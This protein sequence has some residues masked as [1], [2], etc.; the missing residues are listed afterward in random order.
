MNNRKVIN[1]SNWNNMNQNVKNNLNKAGINDYDDHTIHKLNT[2]S[3]ENHNQIQALNIKP[4]QSEL[5]N[6]IE[7]TD[8]IENNLNNDG[9]NKKEILRGFKLNN[10][11]LEAIIKKGQTKLTLNT[12]ANKM[13]EDL[14]SIFILF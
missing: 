11:E 6:E 14:R 13:M 10:E 4:N 8:F 9:C 7:M 3:F 1:N 5:I 12:L 2:Y